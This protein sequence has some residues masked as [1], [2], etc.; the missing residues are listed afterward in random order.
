MVLYIDNWYGNQTEEFKKLASAGGVT[1]TLFEL[2]C[3]IRQPAIE[4][5]DSVRLI[6]NETNFEPLSSCLLSIMLLKKL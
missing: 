5:S 2:N 6:E 3:G 1:E 4:K